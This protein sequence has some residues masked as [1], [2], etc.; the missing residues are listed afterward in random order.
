MA[1]IGNLIQKFLMSNPKRAIWFMTSM[2][3][4]FWEKQG[5]KKALQ[6]FHEA[7]EK[8]PAYKDFLKKYGV[9]DHARIKTIE[10]LEK[11]IP[12]MT[13]K[14][15]LQHYPLEQ[16]AKNGIEGSFTLTMSGG[17]TG[18]SLN[19]LSSRSD[20][21][22]YPLGMAAFFD[23]FWDICS[24]NKRVLF[25]NA[26]ALGVWAAGIQ[27]VMV[28]KIIADK[29][30]NIA[31]VSPG[32][33]SEKVVDILEAIGKHYD[34]I[35]ICAYPTLFKTTLDEGEKRKIQWD[36]LN[37]KLLT[38]G[39]MLDNVFR[40]YI[41][42]KLNPK[43][44]KLELIFESFGGSDIGNLGMATPLAVEIKKL[45]RENKQ[46]SLEIFGNEESQGSI[47]Q[48]NPMGNWVES[49][50]NEITITKPSYM[51]LIR[52]NAKDLGKVFSWD[53]MNKILQ[54]NGIDI[55][56]ELKKDGWTKPSFKWPFVTLL[57]RKDWAVSFFGAKIAPQSIQHIFGGDS[58]IRSFKF[59]SKDEKNQASRFVIFIELQPSVKLKTSEKIKL[60]K[61]YHDKILNHLI[62]TNFDFK[63]AYSIHKETVD[64]K[65]KIYSFDEGPFSGEKNRTRPRL[66]I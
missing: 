51:P 18:K 48:F 8:V 52:Y 40:G 58:G 45:T 42:K 60:Q 21:G 39:E 44:E 17:S 30:K 31:V 41:S 16:L 7:A 46:L 54:N 55:E 12:V 37:I 13:K 22:A 57:G 33:D 49:I 62:E 28:F 11:N 47:F 29:Y 35:L 5:R 36:K 14:T 64:P 43:K 15:Y 61:Y 50:N 25:I 34:L 66:V 63:D 1:K 59:A 32:A 27:A 19:F 4:S 3:A 9:K 2:P 23:Y 38:G 20:I 26:F 65:I 53:E 24:Q 6:V 56:K 10:G